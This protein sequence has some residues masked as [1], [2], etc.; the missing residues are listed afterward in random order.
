MGPYDLIIENSNTHESMGYMIDWHSENPLVIQSE[1]PRLSGA[2]PSGDF[3]ARDVSPPY[4]QFY[5]DFR[6]G[7]GQDDGDAIGASDSSAYQAVKNMYKDSYCCDVRDGKIR[8]GPATI[9]L[10]DC[11]ELVLE[12]P[13]QTF[14]TWKA[15]QFWWYRSNEDHVYATAGW[16]ILEGSGDS[17][18]CTS[19]LINVIPGMK[20]TASVRI[21]ITNWHDGTA[22]VYINW[23]KD[24][25]TTPSSTPHTHIYE[26]G[27]NE[28][29]S[30]KTITCTAPADAAFAIISGAWIGETADASAQ[31]AFRSIS[32][33]AEGFLN[34]V[35]EFGGDV[36]I[37]AMPNTADPRDSVYKLSSG[38]VVQS[39]AFNLSAAWTDTTN[40]VVD[41][42]DAVTTPLTI[43]YDNSVTPVQI[44][45]FLKID[46]E[47]M[48]V[49]AI[50]PGFRIC[51]GDY[52]ISGGPPIEEYIP[53]GAY[54]TVIRGQKDT[55]MVAHTATTSIYYMSTS[56]LA[57]SVA[58][59][60]GL[61]AGSWL[62]DPN[63]NEFVLVTSISGLDL[64][65]RRGQCGTAENL[66]DLGQRW[67]YYTLIPLTFTGGVGPD[68]IATSMWDTG[69]LLAVSFATIGGAADGACWCLDPPATAMTVL[70]TSTGIAAGIY[71]TGLHY[72]VVD[73][74]TL[75]WGAGYRLVNFT[76]T[77]IAGDMLN[78]VAYGGSCIGAASID[79]WV[80]FGFTSGAQTRIFK[81][82]KT[83]APELL[84]VATLPHGFYGTCMSVANDNLYV[85][86]YYDTG[87][88]YQAD[89]T[90]KKYLG[91]VYVIVGDTK[92]LLTTVGRDTEDKV[93]DNRV[94]SIVPYGNFLYITTRD[95]VFCW[96]LKNAGWFHLMDFPRGS[97]MIEHYV[98]DIIGTS[99][100]W[101]DTSSVML[102]TVE[103]DGAGGY[104]KYG[105]M[106]SWTESNRRLL[107]SSNGLYGTFR[108]TVADFSTGAT[109]SFDIPQTWYRGYPTDTY[110]RSA[111][112]QFGI[113]VGA[114]LY[115]V[116]LFQRVLA[117][118]T[119]SQYIKVGIPLI[120]MPQ[121]YMTQRGLCYGGQ[122]W[123][124]TIVATTSGATL[125][126]N[127]C[128]LCPIPA[129]PSDLMAN[130]YAQA[131]GTFDNSIFFGSGW[132][133]HR[134]AANPSIPPGYGLD[135]PYES[136]VHWEQ[137]SFG[138]IAYASGHWWN[139]PQYG[140]V[141]AD[142]SWSSQDV[143]GTA[144]LNGDLV[145]PVPGK[146]LILGLAKTNATTGWLETSD[147]TLKLG[148]IDKNF[149]AV[150]IQH[151]ELKVGQSIQVIAYIDGQPY[152][153]G[154]I[155]PTSQ[156]SGHQIRTTTLQIEG[157]GVIGKIVS[158]RV[159]L[160][161]SN[162]TR[163]W[164]D[165]LTVSGITIMFA[166]AQQSKIWV[167]TINL[168]GSAMMRN[169]D[170]IDIDV[171][172]AKSFLLGIL[173][174]T[175]NYSFVGNDMFYGIVESLKFVQLPPSEDGADP[176]RGVAT[177]VIREAT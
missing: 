122:N 42:I 68:E 70:P 87:H 67:T 62:H 15:T 46:D 105:S 99:P 143:K 153:C 96:D 144:I 84:E 7:A 174:S 130:V 3:S 145:L 160:F 169:G 147:T 79:K 71:N 53:S 13:D 101:A 75:N 82:W 134:I 94:G 161:D 18:T 61:V 152:F 125:Y 22:G 164:I 127:G 159:D 126:C 40:N 119:V 17:V 86:G 33:H 64:T 170:E 140:L 16:F 30:I 150:K 83:T 2:S 90:T 20:Y 136:D 10:V 97:A 133:T 135:L 49:I 176:G 43:K 19:D 113:S 50:D 138:S 54:L 29:D 116:G 157:N 85:G 77:D 28:A 102:P 95:D 23:Y 121:V 155:T 1:L 112:G 149:S 31:L 146:T 47:I 48:Q 92:M 108:K 24:D 73:T 98:L 25:G 74:G 9:P 156:G 162:N 44:G 132:A 175:A 129:V 104:T 91:A 57:L 137:I 56:G 39:G 27:G 88:F 128:Y 11:A 120:T 142:D 6:G 107:V 38:T 158:V 124:F 114:N 81:M 21:L 117:N 36:Y 93:I 103:P 171:A 100:A 110:P 55:S 173:S 163:M 78:K 37:S 59:T 8:L 51:N 34:V 165:R 131:T 12:Q 168:S 80:Y 58:A 76:Y 14:D 32:F 45:S 26:E 109:V 139:E 172:D 118:G 66:H 65:I 148:A 123:T 5:S 41:A 111:A 69:Q 141:L 167:T 166:P 89:K 72:T 154:A 115:M 151:N 63:N 177:L 52:F 35:H 4:P 60:T 106:T